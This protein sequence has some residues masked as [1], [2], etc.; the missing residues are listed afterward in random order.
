MASSCRLQVESSSKAPLL[1]S[2]AVFY[3]S[4]Y[5]SLIYPSQAI[6]NSLDW[7][8][9]MAYDL[10][11]AAA[12]NS[13]DKTGPPAA[14]YNPT[15][16]VSG[17]AGIRAWIQAGVAANKLVLGLPFYG[18]GWC[19]VNAN[20]HGIF[21]PANGAASDGLGY[22]GIKDFIT[23]NSITAVFNSTIVT[24]YCYAGTTWIGYDDTQSI[25]TKVTYA[26]GKGLLGYFAWHVGADK[27]FALSQTGS[28]E[29]NHLHL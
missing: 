22:G 5:Y 12:N 17:D 10:Y 4:D 16:E 2:T 19:L 23:Q 27:S 11:T 21:A 26:K 15:S 25:S 13:P 8:N 7:L 1:L 6:S 14:L 24:D 3:S 9:V 20:N 28:Y 29:F 18:R